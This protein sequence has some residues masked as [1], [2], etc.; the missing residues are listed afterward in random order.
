MKN[1][2]RKS[3]LIFASSLALTS[4]SFAAA[5]AH[6]NQEIPSF[7]NPPGFIGT[8]HTEI[9][10][11]TLPDHSPAELFGH[12][13][14]PRFSHPQTIQLLLHGGTYNSSYWSWP[15]DPA[16]RSYVWAALDAGYAVLALDRLGYGQSTRPPSNEVTFAAQAETLHTVV[17]NLKEGNYDHRNGGV[18]YHSVIGV[19]HSFG[20]AEL[21]NMASIYPH[22][23]SAL[24]L[25]GSGSKTS[26]V[27][28]N[29]TVTE[30]KPAS[31][32]WSRFAHLDNGYLTSPSAS[33]RTDLVYDPQ[34]SSPSTI[35]FDFHTE[36]TLT[37]GEISSRP[38]TLNAEAA[39]ITVPTLLLDGQDDSHY[40]NGV[41][42]EFDLDNCSTPI[43]LYQSEETSFSHACFAASVVEHSGHD[44]P[45]EDGAARAS[46][47]MLQWA[48]ATAPHNGSTP[49]CAITGG[50]N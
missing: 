36:D 5:D 41:T 46:H 43:S 23:Y 18:H 42:P 33:D 17:N 38:A 11:V 47:L 20:S 25:T 2:F 30:L 13:C 7:A 48:L 22:D 19:G 49:H 3:A 4:L 37:T 26:L 44:L 8:C 40:C 50:M 10:P 16:F 31:Q 1:I 27:T 6:N 34:F 39:T 45:T 14:T 21:I 9:F 32:V 15:Q 35:N 12:L 29:E 24:I 28:R